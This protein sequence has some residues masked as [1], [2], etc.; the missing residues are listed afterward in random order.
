[1]RPAL[2]IGTGA[3]Y[4]GDRI[5]PA[6]DLVR[7]G[8][9]DYIVFE[10]LAERTVAKA[11]L[12][13][14]KDPDKGYDPLLDRRMRAVLPL[15][16][17][18]GTRI[19]SNMGAANPRKAGERIA[20]IARELGLPPIRIAVVEGD[21]VHALLT[22]DTP[23]LE[24]GA[25]LD[26]LGDTVFSGNAY[27]GAAP[28]LQALQ[29]GADVVIT[30]RVADPSLFVGPIL[31][32]FGWGLDDWPRLGFATMA[33]HLLECGAQITGGYFADP[34]CKTVPDLDRVGFPIGELFE[35]G[36]LVIGKLAGSGGT[37]T[38]ATCKEQLL[39]EVFDPAGY[40][41]PDV[42]ADFS[43]VEVESLGQ[44]RVRLKGASGRPAPATLKVSI[45]YRAGFLGEAQI[46]YAGCSA[47]DR[48]GL[49]LD[50]VRRRLER[51]APGI[52]AEFDVLGTHALL[53]AG[54]DAPRPHEAT[55]RVA[56]LCD[57][58]QLAQRVGEEVEAL[59][60]NGPAGGGGVRRSVEEVIAICSSLMA[61]DLVTP[62][63]SFIDSHAG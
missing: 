56:A 16:V 15:C 13:R 38:P 43:Q 28:V 50:V 54:L 20:R 7:E 46:S 61:R 4:A 36:S 30:G 31:H 44:D 8:G 21:D 22:G 5:S 57:D 3:G 41:T 60:V 45:G 63:L 34:G 53:P 40:I 33:G 10:C 51:V 62:R 47:V 48:A 12:A 52:A 6:V 18:N 59:Y 11:Q 55:A 39:Y 32:H 14:A 17:A 58:E 24:T 25:P 19:V 23:I 37:I 1:M 49:A 29:Q 9:L 26:S 27:L 2:R 42:I 35:D